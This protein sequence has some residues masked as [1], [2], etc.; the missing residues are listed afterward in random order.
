MN[1]LTYIQTNYPTI[2]GIDAAPLY[3]LPADRSFGEVALPCFQLAKELKSS[4]QQIAQQIAGK[5]LLVEGI[6]KIEAT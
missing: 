3:E 6:E 1:L 2:Q 4:P 5:L